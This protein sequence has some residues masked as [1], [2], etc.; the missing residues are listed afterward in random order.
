VGELVVI[1]AACGSGGCAEDPKSVVIA[2]A[3]AV[4]FGLV[5]HR[6]RKRRR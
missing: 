4:V 2:I 5:A 3:I 1:V 6:I